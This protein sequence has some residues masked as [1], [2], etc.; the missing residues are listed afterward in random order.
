MTLA[1]RP[2]AVLKNVP[3]MANSRPTVGTGS[4][5]RRTYGRTHPT[6]RVTSFGPGGPS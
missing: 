1:G 5:G 4:I 2:R 6:G 3:E